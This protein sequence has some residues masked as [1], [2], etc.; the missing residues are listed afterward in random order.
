[1]EGRNLRYTPAKK[2][3]KYNLT[4]RLTDT[5]DQDGI[6]KKVKKF[7]TLIEIEEETNFGKFWSKIDVFFDQ[8][9]KTYLAK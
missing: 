4:L 8:V 7:Y 3:G 2:A 1:M 9:M 5:Q 6:E